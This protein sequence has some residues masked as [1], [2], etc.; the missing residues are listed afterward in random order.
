MTRLFI[1]PPGGHN[2]I[3][4]SRSSQFY[5]STISSPLLLREPP[6]LLFPSSLSFSYLGQRLEGNYEKSVLL[7]N[8]KLPLQRVIF[9]SWFRKDKTAS[10]STQ[11]KAV[12]NC[13][14]QNF[15]ISI[16]CGLKDGWSMDY[17]GCE[18]SKPFPRQEVMKS[19]FT[20]TESWSWAP[21]HF[22]SWVYGRGK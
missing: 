1:W 10:L 22:L 4:T 21:S 2:E 19:A 20:W 6:P 15:F 7:W 17:L 9:L 14:C 13:S 16:E 12:G 3:C 18:L 8:I 5:R 11:R